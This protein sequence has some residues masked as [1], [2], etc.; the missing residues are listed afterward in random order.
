VTLPRAALF[1][2]AVPAHEPSSGA[3]GDGSPTTHEIATE[4][5][6]SA[7]ETTRKA[8]GGRWMNR[9]NVQAAIHPNGMAT[10]LVSVARDDASWVDLG[11]DNIDVAFWASNMAAPGDPP[12]HHPAV[13]SAIGSSSGWYELTVDDVRYNEEDATQQWHEPL[14][15]DLRKVVYLISVHTSQPDAQGKCIV[16]QG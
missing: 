9:L 12:R 4:R 16:R 1:G 15:S 10:V 11:P 6:A 7:G 3:R 14:P 8:R 2:F 5:H 13:L